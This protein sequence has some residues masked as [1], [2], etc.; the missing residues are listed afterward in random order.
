MSFDMQISI[1]GNRFWR[2]SGSKVLG[3]RASRENDLLTLSPSD[4]MLVRQILF[5]RPFS[6]NAITPPLLQAREWNAVARAGREH[7]LVP[8]LYDSLVR[9]EELDRLPPDGAA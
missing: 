7:G 6:G 4:R 2:A 1:S 8:I 3:D 5:E 9:G